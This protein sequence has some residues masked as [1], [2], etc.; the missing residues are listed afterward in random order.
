MTRPIRP[1]R[2]EGDVAF[3]TLTRGYEAIIDAADVP[4]V[5]RFNWYAC[6]QRNTVYASR[7]ANKTSVLMHRVIMDDPDGFQVDHIDGNGLNNRRENMREATNAQNAH[8]SRIQRNNTSGFKGVSRHNRSAKWCA[9]IRLNG[10][11][12]RLGLFHTPEAAHA[13]YVAASEVM[14]GEFARAA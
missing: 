7:K 6:V 4:L 14:H 2:I 12:Y 8:N 9:Q 11:C 10:S 1:I 5:E 13:A 3:V